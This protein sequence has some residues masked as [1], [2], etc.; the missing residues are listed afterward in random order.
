LR[1]KAHNSLRIASKSFSDFPTFFFIPSTESKIS[2]ASLS[3]P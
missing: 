2:F 1:A 3:N